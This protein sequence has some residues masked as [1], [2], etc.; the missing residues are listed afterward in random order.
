MVV[1]GPTE[2]AATEAQTAILGKFC[3]RC[4]NHR[5]VEGGRLLTAGS[6]RTRW[7]CA[8]CFKI[9]S[10]HKNTMFQSRVTPDVPIR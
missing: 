1:Y 6:G 5:K 9:I 4:R 7:V 8:T 10:S 3:T 2:K